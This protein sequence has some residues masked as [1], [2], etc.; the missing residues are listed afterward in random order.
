MPIPEF[1]LFMRQRLLLFLLG[2]CPIIFIDTVRGMDGPQSGVVVVSILLFVFAVF[3]A[4]LSLG[5]EPITRFLVPAGIRGAP[6]TSLAMGLSLCLGAV[7]PHLLPE[8]AELAFTQHFAWVIA[9]FFA[10]L[11]LLYPVV[12]VL[13]NRLVAKHPLPQR[14][15]LILTLLMLGQISFTTVLE[16]REHGATHQYAPTT[17]VLAEPNGPVRARP[18]VLLIVLDTLRFDTLRQ[19]WQRQ[20]HFPALDEYTRNAAYFERGYAGC[21]VTPG[22]HSTLFTGM[23]PSETD[24]L[25]RGL[26]QLDE[27]YFTVAEFLRTY[28]YRTGALVSNARIS[29]RFGFD[30]G[31]EVYDDQ[32][33]NPIVNLGS[34]GDRLSV[35]SLVK[36]FGASYSKKLVRSW[37]TQLF[38]TWSLPTA[39][40]TTAHALAM[41][42]EM[43]IEPGQPWFLFVNY[44]DP[45]APFV[46]RK[47][48]ADAFGPG[49]ESP[50]L[51]R[52]RR[53]NLRFH[54]SINRMQAGLRKGE[55]YSADLNWLQEAYREQCLELDEGVDQF[56]TGLRTQGLLD[57]NTLVLIT[58]DHGEHLGEHGAFH[59]G[60]TLLD[61]EVRVPFLLLGPSVEAGTFSTPV[62]GADFFSTVCYAMGLDMEDYPVTSGVPLQRPQPERVVRFEHGPLRGFLQGHYKMIGQDLGGELTWVEAYDLAEDPQE[63]QNLVDSGLD[64]VQ[65]YRAN[66]PIQSTQGADF[67]QIGDGSIDLNALGYADEMAQ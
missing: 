67:I 29:G 37:F 24:T 2:L 55:D 21:N 46:T 65:A 42:D 11:F 23:L 53:D 35:S 59:H 34:I 16:V 57:D 9:Y 52:V 8:A 25:H 28:G 19:T 49:F 48:L 62:S 38:W 3:L 66:P 64:W 40:K 63:L 17:A 43:Q 5:V 32:L 58:S 36:F 26:V 41:V 31:F 50:V 30:Q 60:S 13:L 54:L 15:G 20:Q 51:E 7:I 56:L 14:L 47:D 33:V 44:I 12:V 6:L 39:A 18:N 27:R 22:G 1:H 4:L 45:H 10:C 61:E